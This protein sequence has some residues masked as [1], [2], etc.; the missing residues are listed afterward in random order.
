MNEMREFIELRLTRLHLELSVEEGKIQYV[1]LRTLIRE[2]QEMILFLDKKTEKE[3]LEKL[4]PVQTE[5]IHVAPGPVHVCGTGL[6]FGCQ[7][8]EGHC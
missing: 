2:Y 3:R 8:C 6:A 5:V 1:V 7:D 4:V